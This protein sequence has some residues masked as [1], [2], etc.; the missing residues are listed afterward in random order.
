MDEPN[1]YPTPMVMEYFKIAEV[2]ASS[3]SEINEIYENTVSELEAL[4]QKI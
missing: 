1:I 2:L 4:W 3:I